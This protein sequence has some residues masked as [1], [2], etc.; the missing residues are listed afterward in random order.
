MLFNSIPFA[1][2]ALALLVVWHV[3]PKIP[4]LRCLAIVSASLIFYGFHKETRIPSLLYIV[5]GGV[6]VYA[7][8]FRVEQSKPGRKAWFL[9]GLA[10]TVGGLSIFKYENIIALL[11]GKQLHVPMPLAVS[12]FSSQAIIIPV[13]SLTSLVFLAVLGGV[14]ARAG[15]A[16]I[17]IGALRV[18]FWGALAMALTA[19][20]GTLFGTPA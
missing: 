15:G 2:F 12:F 16:S 1:V 8:G 19:A 10:I 4:S 20:V 3:L 18:T 17:G 13:V 9:L 14:A 11:F 5:V 6:S 7:I